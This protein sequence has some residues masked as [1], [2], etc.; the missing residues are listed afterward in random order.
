[1]AGDG[2]TSRVFN[3][4]DEVELVVGKYAGLRGRVSA[5]QP[6]NAPFAVRIKVDVDLNG[7]TGRVRDTLR[8]R[9]KKWQRVASWKRTVM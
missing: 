7:F 5:K 2:V 8:E 3:V 6:K 1:M 4:G 9:F